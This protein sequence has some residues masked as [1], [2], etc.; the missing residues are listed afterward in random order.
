M[1]FVA[2]QFECEKGRACA[3]WTIWGKRAHLLDIKN[4]SICLL[5]KAKNVHV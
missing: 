3:Q 2:V 1:P 5:M 4:A